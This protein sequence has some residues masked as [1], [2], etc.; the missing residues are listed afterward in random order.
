MVACGMFVF[1]RHI[2]GARVIACVLKSVRVR[3]RIMMCVWCVHANMLCWC[4]S[5]YYQ[6]FVRFKF[7]KF[8]PGALITK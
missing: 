1:E 5:I 8:A 3:V 6:V 7:V 2:S 4:W